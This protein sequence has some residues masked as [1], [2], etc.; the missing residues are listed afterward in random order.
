MDIAFYNTDILK[1]YT[2][3][4]GR[5][6]FFCFCRAANII[7]TRLLEANRRHDFTNIYIISMPW[8]DEI[9]AGANLSLSA[10]EKDRINSER[11]I[12]TYNYFRSCFWLDGVT[13]DP[14]V[15]TSA[16][17]AAGGLI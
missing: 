8:P 4:E 7:I 14:V 3:A 15:Q 6:I 1:A 16:T 13:D 12:E 5:V 2:G 11:L 10:A 17:A 9:S